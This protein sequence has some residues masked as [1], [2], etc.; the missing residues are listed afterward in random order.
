MNANIPPLPAVRRQRLHRLLLLATVMA[1]F[2]AWN[3]PASAGELSVH[4]FG[5]IGVAQTDKP[6]GW[7]YARALNQRTNDDDFRWDLD[8]VLGIQLNY[9]PT[10]NLELV[11]Q[12]AFSRLDPDAKAGDYLELAF[13][14]W[15]PDA[16]WALRL[17]RVDLDAY[18]LSDHR[19]VGFTYP[20][21]RPPVEYYAR[22]PSSLDGGDIS[23]SW[24]VGGAQWQTKLFLGSTAGGTGDSRLK[25]WPLGG[26][27]VSRETDG[28]LLRISVLRGRTRDNIHALLPLLD[29]LQQLQQLP[30]PQ[31]AADA[32]QMEALLTTRH[33]R[34]NYV[35]AAVAYD[36]HDWLLT[37]ELNRSRVNGNQAIS[38]TSGYL[39]IGRRFGPFS[40]FVTES[41]T[42][43]D[44]RAYQAPDWQTQLAAMGPQMAQQAQQLANGATIAINNTAPHQSTTSLGVR[45]DLASRLALKAQWDHVRAPE[46]G[47]ALWN[48]TD[49]R[50]ATADVVAVTLDFVF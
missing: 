42:E 17:G 46:G 24:L 15:R 19:D 7:G 11:S 22:M 13:L 29:G 32:A 25:L 10:A 18:M 37:A 34:T 38:F 36:R 30:V 48:P 6:A 5:T 3:W 39:S 9:Q 41:A 47:S 14:A 27:M 28:L 12:A 8:T 44:S 4:G 2:T 1:S 45:W 49:G 23:R 31:V 16:D 33:M 26:L 35:A 50:K 43:R 40:V 20:F 21:I